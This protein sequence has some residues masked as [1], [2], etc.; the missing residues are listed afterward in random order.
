MGAPRKPIPLRAATMKRGKAERFAPLVV[1]DGLGE[2]PA[3][4]DAAHRRC[5]GEVS[6]LIPA[7][8]AAQSDRIAGEAV[9]A[10]V[11]RL[12]EG[13]ANAA[14]LGQL[15][16]F[17]AHFGLTPSARAAL[18]LTAPADDGDDFDF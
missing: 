14:E 4:F 13:K 10:L 7:G 1:G 3:H 9:V 8:V 11:M 12:R 15:R 16:A 5:W 6:A 18:Q 17:L 2:P